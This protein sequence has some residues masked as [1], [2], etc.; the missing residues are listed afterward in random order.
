MMVLETELKRFG[1]MA[2]SQLRER[3]GERFSDEFGT[4]H[5]QYLIGR[6]AWRLQAAAYGGLSE[7]ALRRALE[8]ADEGELRGGS[9]ARDPG[10]AGAIEI[11]NASREHD[12]RLPPAGTELTRS[13]RNRTVSVTVSSAGFTYQGRAYGSLS[14]VAFAATGTRWNGLLFFGIAKRGDSRRGA[15]TRAA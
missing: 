2:M 14:A 8:V 15:K 10:K 11:T 6:I 9:P 5:R 7:E 4:T 3:Y 12:P 1:G 13:Y